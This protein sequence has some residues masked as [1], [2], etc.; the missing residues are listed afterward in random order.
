MIAAACMRSKPF[1]ACAHSGSHVLPPGMIRKIECEHVK[2]PSN[3]QAS[4]ANTPLP[5]QSVPLGQ[6]LTDQGIPT[7]AKLLRQPHSRY[8]NYLL[9]CCRG[10][11]VGA[12]GCPVGAK[13]RVKGSQH[14][15][16]R[17]RHL[18]TRAILCL[19]RKPKSHRTAKHL[20]QTPRYRFGQHSFACD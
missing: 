1:P 7:K 5:F 9:P 10:R 18:N 12:S 2:S 6:R 15:L 16:R 13:E 20:L 14:P 19:P 8:R 4:A 3:C 17:H 11:P